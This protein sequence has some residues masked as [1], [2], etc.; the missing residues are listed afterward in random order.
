[1]IRNSLG[2]SAIEASQLFRSPDQGLTIHTHSSMASPCFN[3][4]RKIRKTTQYYGNHLESDLTIST[5]EFPE[6]ETVEA[7]S[8]S[9]GVRA[10]KVLESTAIRATFWT[11]MDYGCSMALR[12][13]NSLVLTR[14]LM[15]ESFGLMTLVTTL[16]VGISLISDIGLGPSVIQ[17]PRGDEPALLNTVWTLQVLR[18][19]GIFAVSLILAWPMALIYH[20][21]RLLALIPALGLNV[22]IS[23]FN[24]TN[25]L[26]MSRHMGVRRVFLLDFCHPDFHAAGHGRLRIGLPVGVGAGHRS[27]SELDLP[28]RVQ[29]LPAADSRHTEFL[30]LGSREP[31]WPGSLRQ[32]DSDVHGLLLLCVAGRPADSWKTDQLQPAG[33][34]R[35]RVF[36]FGYS[37]G[38]HLCVLQ[39][40]RLSV[41][42][43]DGSFADR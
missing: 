28:A 16:V 1:M 12:V 2:R 18:G 27:D 33:G 23:S 25:L 8:A 38:D 36:G 35:H 39:S 21:P 29:L 15:P 31:A 14:L 42:R 4:I 26:S 10:R 30:L 41:H 9:E 34:L 43:E 11:V 24:S 19:L 17:N 22:L 6:P 5:I 13:V 20:E 37:A 32:M 3:P 7:S 40:S